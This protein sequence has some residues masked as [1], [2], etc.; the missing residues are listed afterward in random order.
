MSTGFESIEHIVVLMLE[1]RSFDNILGET[2]EPGVKKKN[3]FFPSRESDIKIPIPG[4]TIGGAQC[5]LGLDS[6]A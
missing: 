5:S 4:F 2:F 1:N 3:Y 6:N